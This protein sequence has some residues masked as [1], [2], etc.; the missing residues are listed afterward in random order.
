MIDARAA[1]PPR[2]ILISLVVGAYAA[3]VAATPSLA[4]RALLVAP[5][6][7]FTLLW[8]TL[9][10]P[11]RWVGG[12]IA[13]AILLPPLPIPIGDS[14]PHLSLLFAAFGI[15]S[16]ALYLRYWRI[17]A[18][19]LER[20]LIFLF[21]ILVASAGI[22]AFFS[23]AVVAAQTLARV[24]LFGIGVYLYFFTAYVPSDTEPLVQPLFWAAA[25]SAAIAC[26]DFYYQ[27]PAPAGFGPQYVWL[28]SGTY[29]R[30]AQGIFYE[31]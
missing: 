9:A 11:H 30:R 26:V 13:A 31:A 19:P 20:A 27:L 15:L 18:G 3:L 5:L 28:E 25:L 12:F 17:T 7:L 10:K 24:V 29:Y 2:W 8:W 21:L 1:F 23:G 14:G 22:A 6:V 16:G 4:S